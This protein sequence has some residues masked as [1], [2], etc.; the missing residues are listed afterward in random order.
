MTTVC[1][2]LQKRLLL[3][4]LSFFRRKGKL[5]DFIFLFSFCGKKLQISIQHAD[6]ECEWNVCHCQDLSEAGNN[7]IME[8]GTS[9]L[10][11]MVPGGMRGRKERKGWELC[12]HTRGPP[13]LNGTGLTSHS[14]EGQSPLCCPVPMFM[15]Y[16]LRYIKNIQLWIEA[17]GLQIISKQIT[18]NMKEN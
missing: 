15:S 9:Y 1:W 3:A 11:Y 2:S 7:H 4:V 18:C 12:F 8:E 6:C 5:E 13:L 17:G 16:C 10:N 14:R